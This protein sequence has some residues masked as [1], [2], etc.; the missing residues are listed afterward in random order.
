LRSQRSPLLK[1]CCG[2]A[3]PFPGSP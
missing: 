1:I 2:F 3:I